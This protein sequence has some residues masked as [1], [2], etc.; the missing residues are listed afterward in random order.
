MS[1]ILV[2]QKLSTK[3]MIILRKTLERRLY[4]KY[5]LIGA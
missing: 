3:Q 2:K 1:F 5:H 4:E